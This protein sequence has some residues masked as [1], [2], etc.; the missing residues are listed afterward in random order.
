MAAIGRGGVSSA[1]N[2]QLS[3]YVVMPSGVLV[4]GVPVAPGLLAEPSALSFAI[5]DISTDEKRMAPVQVF[6]SSGTHPVDLT[7]DR[8]SRGRYAAAWAC[9]ADE[10]VGAHEIR[11]T[12]TLVDGGEAVTFQ[13]EFDVLTALGPGMRPGYALI[14]AMREEGVTVEHVSDARLWRL[15]GEATRYIEMTTH[16]FFAPRRM[17]LLLDGHGSR[18]L[19]ISH[20]IVGIESVLVGSTPSVD[21]TDALRIY[22]RHVTM[23]MLSPDDREAPRIELLLEQ[24]YVGGGYGYSFPNV[25]FSSGYF[26]NGTQNV[27]VTGVFGYTDSDGLG[28][29]G[30]TPGP[31]SEVTKMLVMRKLPKLTEG[32]ERFEAAHRHRL[33]SERTREQSYTLAAAKAGQG[34][35]TTDWEIDQILEAYCAPIGIAST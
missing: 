34:G 28:G 20:P 17:T 15:I 6:P 2:P 8:V 4:D 11:W 5:F 12:L 7:A 14:A 31:I 35:F 32:E 19:N 1:A 24:G 33:T 26:P 10:P 16:R 3:F 9:P 23:G 13:R 27:Q 30:V 21:I 29:A 18:K 22:N 25:A